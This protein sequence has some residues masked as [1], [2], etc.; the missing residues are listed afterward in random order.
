MSGATGKAKQPDTTWSDLKAELAQFDRVGLLGLLKDLHALGPENRAFLA[1][2]LGV[3]NTPL[4]PHK[5]VIS[6]WV[7]PDILRG[8]ATSVAKAKMAIADYGM[9]ERLDAVRG[10]LR[11]VGWGVSDAVNEIWHDHIR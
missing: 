2:R 5:K 8:Q 11:G 1:A 10:A 7:H 9:L 4:A 3:G 6:R